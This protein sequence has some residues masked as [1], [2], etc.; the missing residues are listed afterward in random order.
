MSR[1]LTLKVSDSIGSVSCL[2]DEPK[3]PVA[4][5]TLAHGAGAPMSHSFLQ[6]LTEKLVENDI[7]VF[8]FNFPYMERKSK[9]P[10][11]PAVAEKTIAVVIE[12]A[13][14]LFPKTP[15]FVSGKSFGGRMSSQRLSKE[16]PDYVNGIIFYGFPLH[17]PG[18]PSIDRA[19]HLMDIKIPMLFLQGTRDTLATLD[20]IKEVTHKLPTSK[21]IT[22]EGADHSFKQG[23]K[24]FMDELVADTVAWIKAN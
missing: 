1:K 11:V 14:E 6:T 21:L 13:H 16:C 20:L 3:N 4:I 9:R 24:I 7:T 5:L 8:R 18:K 22:Y 23:K 12:K 19:N 2:I 10:D 17:A 15:L